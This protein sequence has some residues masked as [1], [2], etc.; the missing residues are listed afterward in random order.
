MAVAAVQFL[1]PLMRRALSIVI[2]LLSA[3]PACAE[4]YTLTLSF[5]GTEQRFAA[6][7]LLARP[8]ASSIEIP[9]DV[10]YK[11]SMKYRAVPLLAL[12]DDKL[13][14]S[15]DTLEVRASDGFVSQIPL[16]LVEK[17]ASGGSVAWIAVEDR[18]APWPPLPGKDVSAGPFYLVWEHPEL[19]NVGTEL[20]PYQTVAITGVE[21]PAHRWPQMAVAATLPA[22]DPA[23][24]GQAVFT[25]QCMPCHRMK[26]A[27]A[28]DVGPDLGQPMNPT[29]YLTA[30]GLRALIRN[31]KAVR[32]WPQQQ[33]PAFDAKALSDA[34]LDAVIAYLAH[35]ATGAR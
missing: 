5:A 6:S 25:T 18:A 2:A 11:R 31:P 3:S 4:T 21:S 28:A 29:Q 9:A 14:P 24:H 15:L 17:G 12:L 20:W 33:M 8:D 16:A 10:S 13:D 1:E 26:G 22:D 19:S 23:R 34:D 32:T 7:E 27:G 30:G 35:M